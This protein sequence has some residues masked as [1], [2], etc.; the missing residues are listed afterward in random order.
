MLNA[1]WSNR[2][3]ARLHELLLRGE[4]QQHADALVG[5]LLARRLPQQLARLGVQLLLVDAAPQQ[6]L[7]PRG[8]PLGA[9]LLSTQVRTGWLLA[10]AGTLRA[11]RSV[12]PAGRRSG[13][14]RRARLAQRGDAGLQLQLLGRVQR[15]QLAQVVAVVPAQLPRALDLR[16]PVSALACGGC[17][18][19]G[20][21][22]QSSRSASSAGLAPAGAG[23][24]SP[25]HRG[26]WPS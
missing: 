13:A 12:P 17:R 18:L 16:G 22:R 9:R 14:G 20:V 2:D 7:P 3:A 4:Q 11:Y 26:C 19:R 25:C 8:P 10:L 24:A 21:V 5:A 23:P 6:R 15:D 1:A